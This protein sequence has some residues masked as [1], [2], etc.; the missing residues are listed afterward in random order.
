MPLFRHIFDEISLNRFPFTGTS[1]TTLTTV[2]FAGNEGLIFLIYLFLF[3]LEERFLA[4]RFDPIRF[5]SIYS[6]SPSLSYY[7]RTGFAVSIDAIFSIT[8]ATVFCHCNGFPWAR[9]TYLR[10]FLEGNWSKFLHWAFKKSIWYRKVFI[11]FSWK[12]LR[13][14]RDQSVQKYYLVDFLTRSHFVDLRERSQ[15]LMFSN[16]FIPNFLTITLLEKIE[17]GSLLVNEHYSFF[18]WIAI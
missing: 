17:L 18:S 13:N 8:E 12:T 2:F 16:C 7:I 14:P 6:I 5:A 9:G 10:A 11:I 15:R 3:L 4:G 1:F